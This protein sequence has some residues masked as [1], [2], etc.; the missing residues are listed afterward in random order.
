MLSCWRRFHES[1]HE[2]GV[3]WWARLQVLLGV[4]LTVVLTIDLSPWF[5]NPRAL[6]VYLMINGVVTELV[7]RSR[8]R[9]INGNLYPDDY[10]VRHGPVNLG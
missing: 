1:F 7:R 4:V 2:S 8:T 10:G 6:T 9:V 3:I 5:S